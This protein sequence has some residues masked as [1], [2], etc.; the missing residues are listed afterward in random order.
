MRLQRSPSRRR[1]LPA[2]PARRDGNLP[3]NQAPVAAAITGLAIPPG[4]TFAIRW[5][6]ANAT[7]ADDGLA[8]DDFTLIPHGG[9]AATVSIA[10]VSVTEG[11]TGTMTAT[12]TV[13]VSTTAHDGVTFSIATAGS[14]GTAPATAGDDYVARAETGV[15][16][17]A[18]ETAYAFAVTINGDT[19]VEPDET[20]AVQLS[21][22]NGALSGDATAVGTIVNDDE[23][24]PVLTDVVISQVYGAGGNSGAT[25]THDFVEL[26]NPGAAPVTLDGW[27]VQYTSAAGTGTWLVT[28]LAGTIQPGR[29]SSCRWPRAPAA[30]SRCPR[31][32]RVE[33]SRMAAGAGKVALQ[34]NAT[35]IVG[36]CP[37]QATADLVGYGAAS[38]FEGTAPT[39]QLSVSTAAIRKRGGCFDSDQNGVDFSVAPP[40]PRNSAAPARSC[41]AVPAQIHDIQGPG[42][43]SPLAGQD[44][45]T[46]GIVTA[47]KANGFFL[48][49]ADD[50]VDADAATS[51]GLFAFTSATPAVAVGDVVSARGT[52]SEF[53]GLTQIESSLPG[54]VTATTSVTVPAPIALTPSHLDPA[55]PPDQLERFEGMRLSAASLTSVAPTD[56]FGEIPAVLAGVARPVREPGIPID[57]PVPPDPTTGVV[58]CCIP[59]FDGNPERIVVDSDGL[60]GSTALTVTSNVAIGGVTGPLDFSFGA[61]KL[62]P[63]TAPTAGVNMTG[64]AVR[65]AA[66]DEFTV[67]GFNIENFAASDATQLTQGVAGDPRADAA[68][69]RHRPHR[70]PRSRLAADARV[71]RQCRRGGRR[72]CRTRPTRQR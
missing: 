34:T 2:R 38:C 26:F 12:F 6:D 43:A 23:P 41:V 69:G 7:G 42:A 24:P 27:S 31:P 11:N 20:F 58:D 54:D 40:T 37:I 8:V 13:S 64:R 32:M 44:V 9:G 72:A 57:D 1:R 65:E 15:S 22:I 18:G 51:E 33:P 53:F 3:G 39:G 70:D 60:V 56:G 61:Y 4:N 49:A 30:R 67:G 28:P 10:D 19:G 66:A 36:G 46:T 17:P 55:G 47:I 5:I 62:L 14:G 16:I 59:R 29:I 21:D 35:A 45:I 63:E 25:L 68:A 71:A 48:Q 50:A 52:V